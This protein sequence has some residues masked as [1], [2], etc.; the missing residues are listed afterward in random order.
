MVELY[1]IARGGH[2][3]IR[4]LVGS[5]FATYC[6]NAEATTKQCKP[7]VTVEVATS[8]ERSGLVRSCLLHATYHKEGRLCRSP[9]HEQRFLRCRSSPVPL[10]DYRPAP[11]AWRLLC[12]G[13]RK[14]VPSQLLSG[15]EVYDLPTAACVINVYFLCPP[16]PATL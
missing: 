3:Q 8:S 1:F 7:W 10:T 6:G 14:H 15:R 13:Q 12:L 2:P 4:I 16:R 9:S 5:H 11:G